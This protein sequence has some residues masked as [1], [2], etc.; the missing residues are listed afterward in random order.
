MQIQLVSSPKV[1]HRSPA[2]TCELYRVRF[3]CPFFKRELGH[4]PM[5]PDIGRKTDLVA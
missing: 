5:V 4:I 3:R 1:S 2:K